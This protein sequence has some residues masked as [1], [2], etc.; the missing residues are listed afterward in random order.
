MALRRKLKETL[1]GLPTAGP[2]DSALDRVAGAIFSTKV[3]SRF[4]QSSAAPEPVYGV[5]IDDVYL[6]VQNPRVPHFSSLGPSEQYIVNKI[7][8][9]RPGVIYVIG[10]IGVGKTRFIHF[11]ETDVLRKFQSTGST[12]PLLIH[13]DCEQLNHPVYVSDDSPAIA[14]NLQEFLVEEIV[15]QIRGA[16]L[17]TNIEEVFT[18][19]DGLLSE[20]ERA[21][22]AERNHAV[23]VL[24][25]ML[26][27]ANLYPID[28]FPGSQDE[29]VSE[30]LKVRSKLLEDRTLALYYLAAVLAHMKRAY[31]SADPE[32]LLLVI[33]N[34][35]MHTPLTQVSIRRVI[36]PLEIHA[37]IRIVIAARPRTDAQIFQHLRFQGQMTCDRVPYIGAT[38]RDVLLH[39]LQLFLEQPAV[40]ASELDAKGQRQTSE[41]AARIVRE[42]QNS[43]SRVTRMLELLCG[44][45]IRKGLLFGQRLICN[46]IYRV[47]TEQLRDLTPRHL[48]RALFCGCDRTFES[49]HSNMIENIFQSESEPEGTVL[50]KLRALRAVHATRDITLGELTAF[51]ENHGFG[52][53]AI[54][55]A[56]NELVSPYK[57]LLWS[58]SFSHLQR[59]EELNLYRTSRLF[60]SEVGKSYALELPNSLDYIQEVMVDSVIDSDELG[61]G[62]D[63]GRTRDRLE[64]IRIFIAWIVSAEK[65]Q[66][67]HA[68]MSPSQETRDLL[69]QRL[70]SGMIVRNVKE[71]VSKIGSSAH[72]DSEFFERLHE[73]LDGMSVDIERFE[74]E[75]FG[76]QEPLRN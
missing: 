50:L 6:T 12:N 38:P 29:L 23:T 41:L 28:R 58:D 11:F 68:L 17:F 8:A 54:R 64:L 22:G 55:V 74:R 9:P 40:L 26:D 66:V 7:F 49:S 57:A 14:A 10:G 37:S 61:V 2:K 3:K 52:L 44:S 34:L 51:L 4:L 67:R 65:E 21:V 5:G 33:D 60:I 56:V 75:A 30:R 32:L 48:I 36:A 62:W 15:A 73:K 76:L 72:G 43:H 16:K 70:I 20:N 59:D 25:N 69:G 13:I 39:R 18:I 53:R 63:Y 71:S 19:W 47:S 24:A 42:L 1:A 45:S 27:K 35:D 31:Y 46:S